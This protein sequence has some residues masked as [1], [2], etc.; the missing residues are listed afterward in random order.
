MGGVVLTAIRITYKVYSGI[1]ICYLLSWSQLYS[2]LELDTKELVGW[3]GP[4]RVLTKGQLMVEDSGWCGTT[5]IAVAML[6]L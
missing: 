5:R 2:Q 6:F 3:S 1:I 4:D